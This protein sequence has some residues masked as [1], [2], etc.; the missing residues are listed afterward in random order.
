MKVLKFLPEHTIRYA[1]LYE[2]L[3]SGPAYAGAQRR[4]MAKV[5][6]KFE[7]IGHLNPEPKN[8]SDAYLYSLNDEGGTVRLEDIE[9][10]LVYKTL[11]EVR[12]VPIHIRRAEEMM[13]WLDEVKANG[14][15]V[16]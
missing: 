10:D 14:N 5:L 15:Q 2:G 9:F 1:L 11:D 16:I 4:V 3:V 7:Q 6:G 8:P 13:L 12:W